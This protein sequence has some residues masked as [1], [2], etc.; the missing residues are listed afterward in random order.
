MSRS[1]AD[2]G[3]WATWLEKQRRGRNSAGKAARLLAQLGDHR[4]WRTEPA[5]MW[6]AYDEWLATLPPSEPWAPKSKGEQTPGMAA[7]M[8][9]GAVESRRRQGLPPYVTDPQTLDNI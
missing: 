2:L 9:R 1:G 7:G 8:T 3:G 6:V 4:A 5:V